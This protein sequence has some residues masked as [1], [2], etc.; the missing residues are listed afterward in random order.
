M[1][2]KILKAEKLLKDYTK[3]RYV[4]GTGCLDVL[5]DFILEFGSSIL[6]IISANAWAET[7]RE[8]SL[9]N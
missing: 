9:K 3:G 7:L 1:D 5:G 8:K 6:L 4:F 2:E